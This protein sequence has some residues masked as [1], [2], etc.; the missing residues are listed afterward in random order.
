MMLPKLLNGLS[1]V[2]GFAHQN[3]IRFIGDEFGDAFA[4]ECMII[5]HQNANWARSLSHTFMLAKLCYVLK[6]YENTIATL[7]A[8]SMQHWPER[9]D[10][11][12]CRSRVCS[13]NRFDL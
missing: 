1:T 6:K 2:S 8:C 7:N 13:R 11:S 5:H 3:H 12:P 4:Q 9:R 10:E